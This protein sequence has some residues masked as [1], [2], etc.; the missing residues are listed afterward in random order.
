[1]V[2]SAKKKDI[3]TGKKTFASLDFDFFRDQLKFTFRKRP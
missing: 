3:I 2:L 1:M